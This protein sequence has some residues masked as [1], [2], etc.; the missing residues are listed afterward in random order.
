LD[1]T[2][3][4]VQ[5]SE[6]SKIP[7]ICP[8]CRKIDGDAISLHTVSADGEAMVCDNPACRRR[9]PVVDGVPI[10]RQPPEV[11]VALAAD[12]SLPLDTAAQLAAGLPDDEALPILL[13]HLSIYLDAHWA[14]RATPPIGREESDASA[15]WSRIAER[16]AARPV[17][18]AVEL[19]CAGARGV[20]EL[21]R[22]ADVAV[23]VDLNLGM[24]RRAAR[25]LNGERL[26]WSRRMVGRHYNTVAAHAGDLA[27]PNAMLV[28]GDALDPPLA[29]A[30]FQRV[31]AFNV[32]DSVRRPLDLLNVA[33]GLCAPGGELLLA[34]PFAWSSA[35]VEEAQRFGGA[36]PTAALPALLGKDFVVEETAELPWRLRRDARSHTYYWVHY[37]R[38]TRR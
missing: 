3:V 27:A 22:G 11:V 13:E 36:D 29:P 33:T 8:A 23:G 18:H 17:S 37:L 5:L 6:A 14:D 24:L 34:T 9:Y 28:V 31:V 10:L 20:A 21:A 25:L 38:A 35:V 1:D 30:A 19:G 15:F 32:V 26:E 7:L 12:S 4:F 2:L 16:S